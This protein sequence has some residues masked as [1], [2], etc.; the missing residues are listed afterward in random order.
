MSH[1]FGDEVTIEMDGIKAEPDIDQT[2][3]LAGSTSSAD[4][5]H[6]ISNTG[7]A[8]HPLGQEDVFADMV[9]VN[10]KDAYSKAWDNFIAFIGHNGAPSEQDFGKY[11]KHLK[12]ERGLKAS[13]LWSIFSRLNT[14]YQNRYGVKLQ[15]WP[16]LIRMLKSYQAGYSRKCA[17][18]FSIS[19]IN[20]FLAL[21]LPSRKFILRKAAVC[22]AIS[23][24]LRCCE[25]RNLTMGNLTATSE[26]YR[27]D[28]KQS[29]Q[30]GEEKENS[31]I[32]PANHKQPSICM[33]SHVRAY[34]DLLKMDLDKDDQ[35]A[36]KSL[37]RCCTKA[38]KFGKQPM[39][40]NYL[41]AIGKEVA[42]VLNL[43]DADS[44]TGH[45][46][47]RTSATIAANQGATAVE[48][49]K[50]YGWQQPTTA[51]RYIDGTGER[52]KKMA[53]RLVQASNA[54]MNSGTS[55]SSAQE[56]V[57]VVQTQQTVVMQAKLS[58]QSSSGADP[59]QKVYHIHC[60][61]GMN[62][63]LS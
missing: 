38:N 24:G 45:C 32:V 48:L 35:E 43:P 54:N 25:L 5:D 58:N 11:F 31:F 30:R 60:V 12:T 20:S 8:S 57:S 7:D 59:S 44:Y 52:S 36:S 61:P 37:F 33:V 19:E 6:A 55:S 28:Y 47:R 9:P 34:L 39:G 23:G 29:K 26:G 51:L 10:S 1:T 62:V 21:D 46:F 16:R 4:K 49:Q 14:G 42:D 63:Y 41:S 15:Q 50:H 2:R 18:T 27:V 40:I 13:S 17:R 56:N 3:G 22:L 53:E